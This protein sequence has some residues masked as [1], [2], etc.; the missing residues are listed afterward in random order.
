MAKGT[1]VSV[2]RGIARASDAA[3]ACRR[4]DR[5]EVLVVRW[6]AASHAELM[7]AGLGSGGSRQTAR[8]DCQYERLPPWRLDVICRLVSNSG[9]VIHG[10]GRMAMIAQILNRTFM[11]EQLEDIRTQLREDV[12]GGRE[13][14]PQIRRSSRRTM[15]RRSG[16]SS[17][18]LRR[19]RPNR[20][21]NRASSRLIRS[22]APMGGRAR[23]LFVFQ[24]RSSRQ[25]RPER[26]RALFRPAAERRRSRDGGA[27]RRPATR[28]D[29]DPVVTNRILRNYQP[30]RDPDGRRVFDKFSANRCGMDRLRG[31]HGHP[32]VSQ[33]PRL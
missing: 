8:A 15:R 22:G 20:A 5:I 31:C 33:A 19:N 25:Y 21:G 7:S 6:A 23:R 14:G 18:P 29:D 17:R 32:K 9:R 16:T 28:A 2:G 4:G 26:D 10:R 3:R 11:L 13:G 30:S 27:C 24:P 12:A 1:P